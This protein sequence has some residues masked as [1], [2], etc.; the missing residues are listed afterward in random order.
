MILYV[1]VPLKPV[2]VFPG[3]HND[4]CYEQIE[5]ENPLVVFNIM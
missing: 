5:E 3:A 1:I 2:L 4:L